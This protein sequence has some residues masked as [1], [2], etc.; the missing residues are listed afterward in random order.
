[1]KSESQNATALQDYIRKVGVPDI[2]KSD[3]AQSETSSK[4]GYCFS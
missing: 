2:L 3:N 4:M 1:M